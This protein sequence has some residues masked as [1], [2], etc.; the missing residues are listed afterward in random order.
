MAPKGA[1][2]GGLARCGTPGRAPPSP[3]RDRRAKGQPSKMRP[4]K[5]TGAFSTS[6]RLS[7][8]GPPKPA[9]HTV[10]RP[11]PPRLGRLPG[12]PIG[13]GGSH[14]GALAQAAGAGREQTSCWS[15]RRRRRGKLKSSPLALLR[16]A[17]HDPKAACL[18]SN[19]RLGEDVGVMVASWMGLLVYCEDVN[20]RSDSSN[21]HVPTTTQTS[22]SA[23]G[24]CIIVGYARTLTH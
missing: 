3:G 7:D 14:R 19:V 15:R 18:G 24:C 17:T 9:C 23:V 21:R 1:P 4:S 12:V 8:P 16:R 13:R 2:C 11:T 22:S 20:Q 10:V 6:R 5:L